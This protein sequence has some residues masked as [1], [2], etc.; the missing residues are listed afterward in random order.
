MSQLYKKK[1]LIEFHCIFS[2]IYFIL[3]LLWL[4]VLY[5]DS[6]EGVNR[7]EVRLF[8]NCFREQ[9]R[10]Q[11][12]KLQLRICD[13]FYR[14]RLTSFHTHGSILTIL[15]CFFA[16]FYSCWSYRVCLRKHSWMILSYSLTGWYFPDRS[17]FLW[18]KKK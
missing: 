7:E 12:A 16:L 8:I 18:C 13:F 17:F 3:P 6:Q 4:L 14:A 5:F 11:V 9:R 2:N 1:L 10:R 15:F